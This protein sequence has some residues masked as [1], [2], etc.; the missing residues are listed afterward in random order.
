MARVCNALTSVHIAALVLMFWASTVSAQ[1]PVN[2]CADPS[3]Q[4]TLRCAMH[5]NDPPYTDLGAPA[6]VAEI[7]EFT[8]VF[9]LADPAVRCFD[10]TAPTLYVDPAVDAAGKTVVSNKWMFTLTGGG[11]C[12]PEDR[13]RDGVVDDV[14]TCLGHYAD[15]LSEMSSAT[16]E[17]MVDLEGVHQAD[18]VRNPVFSGYNRVRIDK[19][20]F[21]RYNGRVV[22]PSLTDASVGSSSF[23]IHQQGYEIITATFAE[24]L[25]GRGYTTWKSSALQVLR[26]IETLPPLKAATTILFV[27][28]SGAAQG[29][30]HSIDSLAADLAALGVS[31]DVRVAFDGYF[32]ISQETEAAFTGAGDLYDHIWT[33]T[34]PAADAFTFNDAYW[35]PGGRY[36]AIHETWNARRDVSCLQAHRATRDAHRCHDPLHVLLNHIATPFFVREDYRDSKHSDIAEGH[37]LPWGPFAEYSHCM[38]EKCAPVFTVPGEHRPRLNEQADRLWF[39]YWTRSEIARGVDTSLAAPPLA[40]AAPSFALWMPNCGQHAG[41]F[42]DVQFFDVFVSSPTGSRNM[43]SFLA[44]FMAYSRQGQKGMYRDDWVHPGF[45]ANSSGPGCR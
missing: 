17:P 27:G 6:G 10:G 36:N 26:S 32:K 43:E 8:R 35:G 2:D 28:H 42:D 20:S 12:I 38:G 11:S 30:M 14:S 41:A 45:I 5:P 3:N 23:S 39:D 22:H 9:L 4:G 37:E 21:D 31:A 13:D 33:G 44:A 34:T 16:S 24:L 19:C 29:L 15:E 7:R 1:V 18:P 40:F 25:H